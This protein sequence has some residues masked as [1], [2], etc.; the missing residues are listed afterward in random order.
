MSFLWFWNM[1]FETNFVDTS[2]ERQDVQGFRN[3]GARGPSIFYILVGQLT[4]SKSRGQVML[5]TVLLI[6]RP[7]GFLDLLMALMW[8][9]KMWICR[10]MVIGHQSTS[11]SQECKY[12]FYLVTKICAIQILSIL[13]V[14]PNLFDRLVSIYYRFIFILL[15]AQM[16]STVGNRVKGIYLDTL[17]PWL[18]MYFYDCKSFDL[19]YNFYC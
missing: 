16:L 13:Y 11:I 4:L 17:I 14:I 6:P 19:A 1:S 9:D 8:R 12:I 10:L 5:T 18:K 15:K 2:V 3:C 7:P